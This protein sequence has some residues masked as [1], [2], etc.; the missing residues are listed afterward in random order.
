[1]SNELLIEEGYVSI[2]VILKNIL[3]RLKF[4]MNLRIPDT[5]SLVMK[6]VSF[7]AD[8][9]KIKDYRILIKRQIAKY[10]GRFI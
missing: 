7:M 9:V 5:M 10:S 1:M 8:P 4:W 3:I 2:F 6:N